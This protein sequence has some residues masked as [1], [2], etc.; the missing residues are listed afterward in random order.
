MVVHHSRQDLDIAGEAPG[1]GAQPLRAMR[2]RQAATRRLAG[3]PVEVAP[4]GAQG[5]RLWPCSPEGCAP[6]H[7]R[8]ASA[9]HWPRSGPLRAVT[10]WRREEL[11]ISAVGGSSVDVCDGLRSGPFLRHLEHGLHHRSWIENDE[12]LTQV[13]R[14]A[15]GEHER[16][17]GHHQL[18]VKSFE[19]EREERQ[20][21]NMHNGMC[22]CV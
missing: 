6:V 20:K 2:P 12:A 7:R 17:K 16:R 22:V 9:R 4:L 5:S 3:A 15:R 21:K 11:A 18:A 10:A 1:R 19:F 13:R 8:P 14:R